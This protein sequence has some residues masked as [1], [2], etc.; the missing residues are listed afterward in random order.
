[1]GDFN[2]LLGPQEKIGSHWDTGMTSH[3]DFRE[4]LDS[5]PLSDLAFVGLP[6]TWSNNRAPPNRILQ[7]LDRRI[8]ERLD[9]CLGNDEWTR[10]FG[11][12]A[13]HHLSRIRSDHCLF[14]QRL[15][16]GDLTLQIFALK[17]RGCSCSS[18]ASIRFQKRPGRIL[19]IPT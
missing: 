9:R 18:L 15:L 1:M 6:Y 4:F 14:L 19:A 3:R 7:R 2:S 10:H 13:V 12:F 16:D 11:E 5:T 17:I 8:L